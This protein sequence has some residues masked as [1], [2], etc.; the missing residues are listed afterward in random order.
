MPWSAPSAVDFQDFPPASNE[1]SNFVYRTR[2]L[3]NYPDPFNPETWIPYELANDANVTLEIYDFHQEC[4]K[5]YRG[6]GETLP[7]KPRQVYL[8]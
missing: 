3:Q 5:P 1:D 4:G 8:M 2:L 7:R 6:I